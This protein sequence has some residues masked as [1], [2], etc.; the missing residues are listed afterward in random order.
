[1]VATGVA[2]STQIRQVYGMQF[3]A[4][5]VLEECG[6]ILAFALFHPMSVD[7]E[8]ATVDDLEYKDYFWYVI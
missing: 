3:G 8:S 5:C 7:A 2:S 6:S 1:M 4:R